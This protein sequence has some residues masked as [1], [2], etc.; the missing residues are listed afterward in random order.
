MI[1]VYVCPQCDS[2]RIVSRRKE[3][4][5]LECSQ[6][7][8]LSDLTFLEWSDMTEEERKQYGKM[9]NQQQTKK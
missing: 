6:K 9:W 4:E 7:M 5:C 3:V 2:V 8:N 1:L